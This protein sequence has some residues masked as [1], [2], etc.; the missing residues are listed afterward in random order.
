MHLYKPQNLHVLPPPGGGLLGLKLGEMRSP[1]PS[2]FI[3]Q[4]YALHLACLGAEGG[5]KNGR[6]LNEERKKV[7][8]NGLII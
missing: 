7:M 8:D 1:K 5:A 6:W 2:R 4:C 3:R